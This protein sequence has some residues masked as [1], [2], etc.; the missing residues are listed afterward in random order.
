MAGGNGNMSRAQ[1]E[2]LAIG[3]TSDHLHTD[4]RANDSPPDGVRQ[5]GHEGR[6]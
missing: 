4:S 5:Q 6:P 3:D 1:D 2:M